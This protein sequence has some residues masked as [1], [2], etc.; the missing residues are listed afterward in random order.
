MLGVPALCAAAG[1]AAIY[2]R[3]WSRRRR[4]A[5]L[6]REARAREVTFRT[7]PDRVMISDWSARSRWAGIT[8][9]MVLL[10][11]GN[12]IEVSSTVA[13]FAGGDGPGVL[14]PGGRDIGRAEPIA[15]PDP[16]AGLDCPHV[17]PGRQG[18]PGRDH[19]H[20]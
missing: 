5:P 15:F 11:R 7:I 2:G 20:R 10:V 16:Q 17:P 14:L 3:I 1:F 9:P 4:E 12:A 8:A 6:R 13:P 19:D 18:Y